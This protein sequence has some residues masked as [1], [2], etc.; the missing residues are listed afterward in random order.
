MKKIIFILSIVLLFALGCDKKNGTTTVQT[1]K[2]F[3]YDSTDIKA[4]VLDNS[5]F[6]DLELRYKLEKGKKYTYRLTTISDEKQTISADTLIKQDVIQTLAYIVSVEVKDVE[7]DNVMEL[8]FVFESIKLD[9]TANGQKYSYISGKKLD[10]LDQQ[11]YLEYE[12]MLNNP[13]SIRMSPTGEI[14]DVYKTDRIA[15]KVLEMRGVKD[16]VSAEEKK[17]F[18][19]DIVNGALKPLIAQVFRSMPSNKVSI[20]SSW[21]IK[22]PLV[23][24]QV[25]Q[26]DNTHNFQLKQFEK[27][28]DDNLAVI[29]AGLTSKFIISPEAKRNN[30]D[31]KNPNYTAE[32]K[33]YFNLTK[34][35]IQKSKTRTALNVEISMTLPRKNGPQKMIRKQSSKNINILELL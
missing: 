6:K 8:S 27:Y 32:G 28:N 22:Q 10:S 23:N 17:L 34:G 12:A 14:L 9:A 26:L 25:F 2:D 18:Q 31:V 15:N 29:N 7:P 19:Q 30:I 21:S 11:R 35:L 5:S 4:Q 3:N 1:T 20:D 16:S 33:I 13:F 24:L